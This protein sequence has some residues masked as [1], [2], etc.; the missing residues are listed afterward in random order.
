MTI[1]S[2][3]NELILK[4]RQWGETVPVLPHTAQG[5]SPSP[6][7]HK[8]DTPALPSGLSDSDNSMGDHAVEALED[9]D[10]AREDQ[11]PNHF[12][13]DPLHSDAPCGFSD[14]TSTMASTRGWSHGFLLGT[15]PNF[16]EV[17]RVSATSPTL[18]DTIRDVFELKGRPLVIEGF[19][20][21][22]RWPKRMFTLEHFA[23][24]VEGNGEC[25][26]SC[27]RE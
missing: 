12:M 4:N 5:P 26:L 7:K 2:R 6:Q 21:H 15:G 3:R 27:L 11:Q 24:N 10:R 19:H 1:E 23:N 18:S 16:H 14:S 20:T 25:L 22:P 17:H 13:V 9:I 8:S